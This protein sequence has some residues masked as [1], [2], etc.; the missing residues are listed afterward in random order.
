MS[1]IRQ[2]WLLLLATLL[3]AAVGSIG[4]VVVS[5]RNTLQ[6]QLDIKNSDNAQSLAI[7]LSQKQ[8]DA[9]MMD[10]LMVAQFDTGFY[11]RISFVRADG[12]SGFAREGSAAP[13]K[14]PSWFV[15]LLPIAA[16]PG[17]AQVSDGWRALG[18]VEVVS[19]T[20]YA[21]DELWGG[22]LRACAALAVVGAVAGLIAYGVVRRIRRPLD[23]AVQQAR[24]LVDGDFVTV[25]EPRVPELA[26][27]TQAMNSMVGRLKVIFD[28]QAKQVETLRRQAYSDPLT[29]LANRKHFMGQL[30]ALLHREDGAME[31]GLLLLRV[32]DLAGVNRRL[33]HAATDRMIEAVA[34][35]LESYTQRVDGCHGGRLNGSDFAL[36]LPVG[37]VVG[38]TAAAIADALRVVLAAFGSGISVSLGAVEVQR[39]RQVGEVMTAADLALARAETLGDFAI[40]HGSV[41]GTDE[42]ALRD[43]RM[44]GEGAWRENLIE[45]LERRRMQLVA[46]PVLDEAGELVHLECPL[47]VQ[48]L[49]DGPLE[50][51]ARWLPLAIRARLTAAVDER[52]IELALAAIEQDG[53]S[54][55]VNVSSASLLDTA[56][57]PR[58]R[59]LLMAMPVASSRLWVEVP[60][61]AA[62]DLFDPLQ[63]LARTLR[64]AGARLGLEHAGER[65][66][67]IERLFEGGIDYVKLDAATVNGVAGDEVRASYVKGVSTMLRGL[68]IMVF[69]E[70]ITD[71]A[72]ARALWNLGVDGVTGPWA[73]QMRN[74][75]VK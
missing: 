68:S 16:A 47:R 74:D 34:Q 44:L 9:G 71:V 8:G 61:S 48:L 2:I 53:L 60:E 70:G 23:Q 33:G 24:S 3:L 56:F 37:G 10:M 72:D 12:V 4:V 28:S 65:L 31:S 55:C 18:R 11:R 54:R 45:A 51:A 38:E 13:T 62:I 73:S 21:H 69:A 20:G 35:V 58:V 50:T 36:C 29:G 25:P 49:V 41:S 42:Q 52:A 1:L 7:A 39:G 46:F 75:L 26:R 17:V 64:P 67:R 14:A 40:E 5:A 19:Q 63:E 66:A 57:A 32:R 6:T 59:A 30:A 27:L 15:D 43:A 22:T